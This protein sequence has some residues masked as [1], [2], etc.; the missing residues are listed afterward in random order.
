M[1]KSLQNLETQED[2]PNRKKSTSFVDLK[3]KDSIDLT[4][5]QKLP[6]SETPEPETSDEAVN[7]FLKIR[8]RRESNLDKV[9]AQP[10]TEIF[11]E[12]SLK[13]LRLYK[14][15]LCDERERN[16][17]RGQISSWEGLLLVLVCVVVLIM[18]LSAPLSF[19]LPRRE[20]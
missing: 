18:F 15:C 16:V 4:S 3:K 14:P 8:R 9:Q 7:E 19:F 5:L 13:A 2:H 6:S 11:D 10:Q 17:N 12:D 20:R 1:N